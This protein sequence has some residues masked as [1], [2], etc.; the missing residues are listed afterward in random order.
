MVYLHSDEDTIRL[1]NKNMRTFRGAERTTESI[2]SLINY[3][4]KIMIF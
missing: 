2:Q 4:T 3:M 1:T